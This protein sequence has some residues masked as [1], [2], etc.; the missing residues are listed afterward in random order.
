MHCKEL[1]EA[2]T[3]TLISTIIIILLFIVTLLPVIVKKGKS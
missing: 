1:Q 2:G 3:A